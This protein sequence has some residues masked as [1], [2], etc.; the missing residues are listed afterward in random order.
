MKSADLE[1]SRIME[2]LL[3]SLPQL[4]VVI[5][6]TIAALMFLA[7]DLWTRR[8]IDGFWKSAF[9]F[10][11]IALALYSAYTCSCTFGKYFF[12]YWVLD[13]PALFAGILSLANGAAVFFLFPQKNA[14][15]RF[16]LI[17][18]TGA[19]IGTW[20]LLH[21]SHLLFVYVGLELLSLCSYALVLG[22]KSEATKV[23]AALKFL[24]Q[25]SFASAM[26][27]FGFSLLYAV[28]QDLTY[29]GISTAL[30]GDISPIILLGLILSFS[31][32]AFKMALWPLHLWAPDVYA[33]AQVPVVAFLSTVSKIGGTIAAFRWISA[34]TAPMPEIIPYLAVFGV[35]ALTLGN[36]GAFRKTGF[37]SMMAFSTVAQSGFLWIAI[38]QSME[39]ST[40]VLLFYLMAMSIANVL[41][42]SIYAI[43]EPL[44][45]D[46][47]SNWNLRN[48]SW[49]LTGIGLLI[50]MISL[51]GLPP[52]VGFTAKL[53][54]FLQTWE[55]YSTAQSTWWLIVLLLGLLNTVLSLYYYIRPLYY[56]LIN[57]KDVTLSNQVNIP[58]NLKALWTFLIVALVA[59]FLQP[60]W[61][62]D[63]L[64]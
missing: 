52:T 17:F 29:E 36:F 48:S 3:R 59:L 43:I 38:M 35:L 23:E 44:Q 42:W 54:L 5:L 30:R 6:L 60:N 40:I 39:G 61:I 19:L 41:L 24:I 8:P 9:A 11:L 7:I 14:F 27:L 47:M 50:A 53:L 1:L 12:G 58:I 20:V 34:I 51:T 37:R 55:W 62:V 4:F 13:Q 56:G 46:Q 57:P 21:S 28:G 31:G 26:M 49:I 32:F 63:L 45:G 64:K 16:Q 22:G 33:A 25:G 15:S 10:F 18:Y 2:E